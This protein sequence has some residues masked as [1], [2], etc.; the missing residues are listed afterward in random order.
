MTR[1]KPPKKTESL[2]VRLTHAVKQAFMARARSRGRTASS[3]VR[4]F[5]E[6]YLAGNDP[7][8]ENRTM[9]KRFATPAAVTSLVATAIAIHAVTPTAASAAPDFKAL[10]DRLDRDRD[11]KLSAEEFAS[12]SATDLIFS[13]DPPDLGQGVVPMM[14]AV[15]SATREALSDERSAEAHAAAP[16][17]FSRLDGDGNGAITFGEFQSHHLAAL[18]HGFDALDA[19]Q[20]ARINQA[21]YAVMRSHLPGD[22]AAHAPS[23]GQLDANHDDGIS[24]EEFLG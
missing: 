23:F 5:I 18:R 9:L 4:E 14:I 16:E 24:W 3:L 1:K 21:E 19:D 8:K 17:I 13:H 6:S 2:E 22:M 15:H 20:D 12:R 10:F 11:G 7:R